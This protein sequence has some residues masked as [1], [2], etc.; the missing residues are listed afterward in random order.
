M[1]TIWPQKSAKMVHK[2]VN[3]ATVLAA[4]WRPF[5]TT[6]NTTTTAKATT[7]TEN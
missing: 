4:L 7:T 2:S 1:K 6:K 5:A 3:A